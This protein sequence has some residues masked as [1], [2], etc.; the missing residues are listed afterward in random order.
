ML[1][2]IKCM[3]ST[4]EAVLEKLVVYANINCVF[5]KNLVKDA[6]LVT[7]SHKSS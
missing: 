2:E 1:K 6:L 5:A 7:I 4:I 3:Y